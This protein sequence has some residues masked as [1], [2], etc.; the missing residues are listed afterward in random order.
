[1][2]STSAAV[3]AVMACLTM[4]CATVGRAVFREPVVDYREARLRGLGITGG[5]L[6]VVLGVYNPNSF[7]LDGSRL[8]YTVMID[9]V[10][11]GTGAYDDHFT[12]ERGDTTVITL[13]LDFNY[14]GLG[15]AGRQLLERGVV[16]Y[17]VTGDITVGTPLGRFTRPY[18]GRG[19]L[20][21][22][23]STSRDAG[24]GDPAKDG[25]N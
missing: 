16:E 21:M 11:L 23:G 20:T 7:R 14:A 8:T 18:S 17:R 10:A 1:M 12:V 3:A 15:V 4:A 24:A 25:A 22:T 6:E 19:R 2:R 5:S 13:P 9:S